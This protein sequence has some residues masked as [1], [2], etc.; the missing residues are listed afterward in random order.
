MEQG[1][2]RMEEGHPCPGGFSKPPERGANDPRKGLPPA[3]VWPRF[4][5]SLLLALECA[6]LGGEPGSNCIPVGTAG[7]LPSVESV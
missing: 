3:Q 2:A 5:D 7:S 1:Q 4:P 6:S